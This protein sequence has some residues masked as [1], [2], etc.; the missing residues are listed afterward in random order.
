MLTVSTVD[1][2]ADLFTKNLLPS[3]FKDLFS[4]IFSLNKLLSP[5]SLYWDVKPRAGG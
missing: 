1:M 4:K 5:A 3:A 2:L